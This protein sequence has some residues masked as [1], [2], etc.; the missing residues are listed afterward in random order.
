MSETPSNKKS[1]T[2][3]VRAPKR[4]S[5]KVSSVSQ[6]EKLLNRYG[7][8]RLPP[9]EEP[10]AAWQRRPLISPDFVDRL[11]W[12]EA[13]AAGSIYR[14]QAERL[15]SMIDPL[16]GSDE[17]FALFAQGIRRYGKDPTIE[18]Y[19]YLRARFPNVDIYIGRVDPDMFEGVGEYYASRGIEKELLRAAC[20]GGDELTVDFLCLRVLELIAERDKPPRVGV[21]AYERRK[22]AISDPDVDLLIMLIYEVHQ[23]GRASWKRTPSS[24]LTLIRHRLCGANPDLENKFLTDSKKL[25]TAVLVARQLKRHEHLSINKLRKFANVSRARAERL[26]KDR[27]FLRLLRQWQNLSKKIPLPSHLGF[28][29]AAAGQKRIPRS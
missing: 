12:L 4:K 3:V 17:E 21:G 13:Q 1:D 23:R 11:L 25:W 14:R 22:R 16:L 8:F 28:S 10:L 7:Y 15:R 9:D 2:Q 5:R 6:P 26:L 20:H 19:L 29:D 27:D 24:F 18:N